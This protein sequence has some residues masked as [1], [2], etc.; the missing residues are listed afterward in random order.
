MPIDNQAPRTITYVSKDE[1]SEMK[2]MVIAALRAVAR[3]LKEFDGQLEYVDSERWNVLWD[4]L[5]KLDTAEVNH[6]I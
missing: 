3:V 2:D 1:I 5:D 4:A 6:A